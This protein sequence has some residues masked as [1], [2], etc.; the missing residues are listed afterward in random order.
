MSSSHPPE[1]EE[2]AEGDRHNALLSSVRQTKKEWKEAELKKKERDRA[3]A[4]AWKERNDLMMEEARRDRQN[5]LEELSKMDSNSRMSSQWSRSVLSED[6]EYAPL[7]EKYGHKIRVNVPALPPLDSSASKEAAVIIPKRPRVPKT[8]RPQKSPLQEFRRSAAQRRSMMQVEAEKKSPQRSS[9]ALRLTQMIQPVTP[10]SPKLP[11]EAAKSQMPRKDNLRR[12]QQQLLKNREIVAYKPAM[13]AHMQRILA[14]VE[15]T[16]EKS[17]PKQWKEKTSNLVKPDATVSRTYAG[18]DPE[19][20][21]F[22]PFLG[23]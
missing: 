2:E 10:S 1:A 12:Y 6:A 13:K 18:E 19:E 22:L 9:A 15:L 16:F 17:S 4:Q 8:K 20:E 5:R 7:L 3:L 14:A 21:P 23:P 11:R